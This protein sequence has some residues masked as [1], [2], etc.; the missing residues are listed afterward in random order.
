MSNTVLR[1]TGGN[2]VNATPAVS[3]ISVHSAGAIT[4]NQ[5]VVR[6][7]R[8]IPPIGL[9]TPVKVS[10]FVNFLQGYDEEKLSFIR[11]GFTEGFHLGCVGV[12]DIVLPKNHRSADQHPEIITQFIAKGQIE[13]RIAGPFLTHPPLF[14]PF[15]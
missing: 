11:E 14:E 9:P 7:Q 5:Y 6:S 15:I 8:K 1:S 13:G 2:G 3:N 10:K 4:P 12:P